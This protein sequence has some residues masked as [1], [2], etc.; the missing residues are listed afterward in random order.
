M[1][2]VATVSKAAIFFANKLKMIF[3]FR[4]ITREIKCV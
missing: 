4:N 1:E 3:N 2:F